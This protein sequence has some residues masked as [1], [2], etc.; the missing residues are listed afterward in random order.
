MRM[1]ISLPSSMTPVLQ[2]QAGELHSSLH[3]TPHTA[4][5]LRALGKGHQVILVGRGGLRI[6]LNILRVGLGILTD[7]LG[8][9]RLGLSI[10][11]VDLRLLT[12]ALGRA[13]IGL[14]NLRVG[15]GKLGLVV[16]RVEL[17][18]MC[19][20]REGA[21]VEPSYGRSQHQPIQQVH[22]LT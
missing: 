11:R 5:F 9:L 21:T 13:R 20:T 12:V 7:A 18:M 2:R 3:C 6:C 16:L 4:W 17:V 19:C 1:V 15:F 22:L 10:L 8:R 14:S